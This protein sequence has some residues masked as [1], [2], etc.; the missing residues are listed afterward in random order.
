M[1][2]RRYA[3]PDNF[4]L[5]EEHS[6]RYCPVC[7]TVLGPVDSDNVKCTKCS[8]QLC[9]ACL[10]MS[11]RGNCFFCREP[12]KEEQLMEASQ[13][14]LERHMAETMPSLPRKVRVATS[15]QC[16][17]LTNSSSIAITSR[18]PS[19]DPYAVYLLQ[20]QEVITSNLK[21]TID[22]MAENGTIAVNNICNLFTVMGY[23]VVDRMATVLVDGV[24]I[25][26]AAT[27]SLLGTLSGSMELMDAAGLAAISQCMATLC[28]WYV[29][30]RTFNGVVLEF[31]REL[32]GFDIYREAP[33]DAPLRL[34]TPPR[35]PQAVRSGECESIECLGFV[36]AT[37]LVC[38][39]SQ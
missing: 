12:V 24:N 30:K 13:S 36:C 3:K 25:N 20:E 9:H 6:G 32:R 14:F 2:C 28:T 21:K 10:I 22:I 35:A 11:E 39:F 15:S 5:C 26:P 33:R 38:Y 4:G 18:E 27:M 7:D 34:H 16:V 8:K 37:T 23:A 1:Q 17:L 29:E 31:D 19:T